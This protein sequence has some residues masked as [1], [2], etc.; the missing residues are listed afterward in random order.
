MAAV[1]AVAGIAFGTTSEKWRRETE[2]RY[3]LRRGYTTRARVAELK[4]LINSKRSE[5]ATEMLLADIREQWQRRA[6]WLES[7]P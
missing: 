5:A 7:T 2:A 6:E 4:T 3:W 1:V